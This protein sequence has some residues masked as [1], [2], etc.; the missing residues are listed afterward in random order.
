VRDAHQG[1]MDPQ[2]QDE[3]HDMETVDLTHAYEESGL[4]I[5]V[6]WH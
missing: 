6:G 5:K 4:L 3:R 1:H 2:T